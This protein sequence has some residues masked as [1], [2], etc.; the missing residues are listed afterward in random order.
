[1][2]RR[3]TLFILWLIQGLATLV[4]M[5]WLPTDSDN[6]ILLGYSATRLVLLG[7]ILALVIVSACLAWASYRH[8]LILPQSLHTPLYLLSIV[9]TLAAPGLYLILRALGET[10]GFIYSAYASR[11]GP[12]LFWFTLSALETAI[13]LGFE[14]A[15]DQTDQKARVSV[16]EILNNSLYAVL[17]LAAI[18]IVIVGTR[19]GITHRNDGSWGSPTTPFMEWQILLAVMIALVTMAL[20]SRWHWL[21]RDR[22]LFGLIYL[23]GCLIWLSQPVNPGFF[24]TPP[25]APNFEIYPFSD[26]MIYAQYAQSA[27]VGNGFMWPDV[28]T[29]PLYISIITWMYALVGQ[30]YSR[31]IALQTI[32]L[33]FFPPVLYL[34]G[35][36]L[37]GKPIGVGLALLAILRDINANVAAPF[38]LNYTYTKIFFSEIPTALLISLFTVLTIRWIRR[39]KP[40]QQAL[41]LGGI[42]GMSSLI[43]LQSAIVLIAVIPVS[44][45]M[46]KSRKAWLLGSLLMVC[47]M[48]LALAPWLVRN[49]IATGGIVLDNPTSQ[50][51]VLA[52]RWSGDNGNT[53]IPRLA[54][55]ND[56]QYSS[57]M[58]SMAFASLRADPGRI[59]WSAANHFFNNEI[60]NL[61]VFPVRDHLQSPAELLWPEHAFWQAWNGQPTPGQL[62]LIFFYIVLFGFGLAAAWTKNGPVGLLPLAISVIYNGWT[63]LFLSSGDRFLVPVDW[64][65]YFYLFLG[66]FTIATMLVQANRNCSAW[67]VTRYHE[68]KV[69]TGPVPFSR[70]RIAMAAV[71][72]TLLGASIALTE[73]VFPQKYQSS[74]TIT[75]LSDQQVI[76]LGRAIY[77]RWYDIDEGEPGS[78]KLGYGKMDEARLVFFLTGEQ[79][80]L[81]I[82]PINPAPKFFPNSSDVTVTGTQEDGF[83][84]A[85]KITVR[86]DG[87]TIDYMP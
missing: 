6:A 55:E 17:I 63:A 16:Q 27:L 80:T 82:F 40:I 53:L 8:P 20:E 61:L 32:V 30:D 87:K 36:E 73:V 43:R 71:V 56:A 26:A 59:L 65:I 11:L 15:P 79:N 47:G 72:I 29:R 77:P 51:M 58:G 14:Y 5:A 45:F 37:A 76:I 25:R 62:T 42:L 85:Q 64:A 52:R 46:I 19:L 74:A 22:H 44:F 1:M 34:L 10:S 21:Q 50:A 18:T 48:A 28:P 69:G 24:A 33:A 67:I 60:S 4:W 41:I 13:Q 23:A 70:I 2:N 54:G 68:E 75:T 3:F 9:V 81:V 86:K 83:L 49:R 7:A 35:K 84:L 78:A 39:P 31:V 57:R 66:L 12:L 38:A